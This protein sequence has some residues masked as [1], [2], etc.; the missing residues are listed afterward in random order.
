MTDKEDHSKSTNCNRCGV[1]MKIL[2]LEWGDKDSA[3][4][5]I[6][7]LGTLIDDEDVPREPIDYSELDIEYCSK[8]GSIDVHLE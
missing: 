2:N 3:N 8:C 6:T 7:I 4:E 1:P 5:L